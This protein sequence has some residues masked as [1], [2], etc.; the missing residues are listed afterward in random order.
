MTERRGGQQ[1]VARPRYIAST[2]LG[3]FGHGRNVS[4]FP[5]RLTRR[6]KTL[7]CKSER[8]IAGKI[9]PL[10]QSNVERRRVSFYEI[11]MIF[12]SDVNKEWIVTTFLKSTE[13]LAN[14]LLYLRLENTAVL[15]C[16]MSLYNARTRDHSH[17]VRIHSLTTQFMERT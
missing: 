3:Q 11:F 8:E 9:H 2:V 6:R 5:I 13:S 12:R 17:P 7:V 14:T 15:C 16:S 1:P 10:E 4:L